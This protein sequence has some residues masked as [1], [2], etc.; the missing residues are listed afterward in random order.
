[1]V[2]WLFLGRWTERLTSRDFFRAMVEHTTLAQMDGNFVSRLLHRYKRQW[3]AIFP[4]FLQK[5]TYT[6]E[7]NR[8]SFD[9]LVKHIAFWQGNDFRE[10]NTVFRAKLGRGIMFWGGRWKEVNVENPISRDFLF[11]L[12]V[13]LGSFCS[14]TPNFWM[15]LYS[16]AV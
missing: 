11:A 12:V 5:Y 8:R 15:N 14:S 3:D 2:V 13:S 1:M 9:D 16:R 7:W 10:H 6:P 4:L